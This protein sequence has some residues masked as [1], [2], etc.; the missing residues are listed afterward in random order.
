MWEKKRSE[1][2]IAFGQVNPTLGDCDGN[3]RKIQKAVLE[4]E[5]SKASLVIFPELALTGYP[6]EDLLDSPQLVEKN[7]ALLSVLAAQS[8]VTAALVGFVEPNPSALG[9]RFFNSAALLRNGKIEL[10]YRKALLPSYDVFRDERYFEPGSEVA[11]FQA[12]GKKFAIT[13]CEDIWNFG[14]CVPKLY[15]VDPLEKV[16]NANVDFVVNLSASPFHVGKPEER[17]ALFLKVAERAHAGVIFCNQVGAQD[18]L[19]FDGG[20]SVVCSN[21]TTH[22]RAPFFEEGVFFWD[23]EDRPSL[24]PQPSEESDWV[25]RAL[26]LGIRDYCAKTGVSK[27]CLGLSGGID[28][29]VVAVL[30]TEALGPENVKGVLLPTEYT[31]LASIEDAELL[32]KNLGIGCQ[33]IPVQALFNLSKSALLSALGQSLLP[34]VQE[35]IQPRLRMALLMAIANQENRLLLNTSNKTELACGYSTL[36]GDSA[37]AL[38]VLSDLIKERVFALARFLNGAGPRIPERVLER[39]PSAELRTNQTDQDSLPEYS[40]LD[41]IVALAVEQNHSATEIKSMGY[42]EAAVDRFFT[43]Y[44]NS[45]FK[46]SQSCTGLRLTKRAFGRGRVVPIVSQKP[47]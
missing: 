31:A 20:S 32:S 30:A 45:E 40:L 42:P 9:K 41:P 29:S 7:L 36:Y 10:V 3:F 26:K 1:V 11:T 39:A 28:S 38:G 18:D 24:H 16:R 2:K 8:K 35:N 19:I 46:R 37:G 22:F 23:S 14:E 43:L 33:T 17:A 12:G 47:L 6:P 21:G 27:V 25:A 4:A 5:R 44:R 34:V 13:I 15:P